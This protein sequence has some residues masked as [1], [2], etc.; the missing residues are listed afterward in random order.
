MALSEASS[1]VLATPET[2]THTDRLLRDPHT[3]PA[4]LLAQAQG[5]H[6]PLWLAPRKIPN[7]VLQPELCKQLA[8]V[9]TESL[10]LE[11]TNAGTGPQS[12]P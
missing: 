2:N 12:A 9:F 1:S 8:G 5:W 10:D 3:H 6:P 11:R 4:G 7:L